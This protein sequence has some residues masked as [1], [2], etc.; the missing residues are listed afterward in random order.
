VSFGEFAR[1]GLPFTLVAV[2]AA[3]ILIWLVW[4]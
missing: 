2:T 3:S 1:I 4:R